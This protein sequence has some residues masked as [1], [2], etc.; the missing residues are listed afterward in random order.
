MEILITQQSSSQY[1]D[2]IEAVAGNTTGV[3]SVSKRDKSLQV[4]CVNA[5]HKAWRGGGRYFRNADEALASYK[6]GE[7]KAIILAGV[8]F[9]EQAKEVAQ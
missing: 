8:E 1:S 7:M 3:V 5:A 9:S 6:S 4:L 2:T